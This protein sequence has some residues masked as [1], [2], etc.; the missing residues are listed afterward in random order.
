MISQGFTGWHVLILLGLVLLV[1]PLIG[2]IVTVNR[3][4]HMIAQGD[5]I[6]ES[7]TNTLAVVA[8][9]LSFFAAI[10]AVVCGHISLSQLNRSH[11]RGWG[12]A[13]ASLWI[14]YYAIWLTAL[15]VIIGVSTALMLRN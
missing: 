6:V 3:R 13:V 10:P 11:E 4:K 7:S 15:A 9:V 2:I 8:F 5:I 1:V 14:G 12:F